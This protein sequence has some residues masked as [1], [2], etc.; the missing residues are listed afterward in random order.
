METTV[1]GVILG[2]IGRLL[3]EAIKLINKWMDNRH[4][5][6]MLKSSKTIQE[7]SYLAKSDMVQANIDYGM[8]DRLIS[9][10]NTST[11][12]KKMDLINQFV[13]PH[14]T[15]VLVWSYV[16]IKFIWFFFNP[17][18]ELTTIWTDSDMTL[19]GGILSFWFL[20]RVLDK[21]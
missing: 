12:N 18:S 9:V 4:E 13:R 21:K 17:N 20:G 7:N 16:L 5:L 14:V 6:A 15:Y 11:G 2:A 8:I 1:F 10:H 3:P 19:L